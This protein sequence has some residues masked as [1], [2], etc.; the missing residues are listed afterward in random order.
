M[1]CSVWQKWMGVR[2]SIGAFDSRLYLNV[3]A[4]EMNFS[5][6]IRTFLFCGDYILDPWYRCS[7]LRD[8]FDAFPT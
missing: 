3:L 6:R 7:Y 2:E 8:G 1:A 4:E 5:L